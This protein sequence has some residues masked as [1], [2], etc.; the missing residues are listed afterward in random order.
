MF[1]FIIMAEHLSV[2]SPTR[3]FLDWNFANISVVL[4]LSL[5]FQ[6][7]SQQTMM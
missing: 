1:L 4:T 6:I 7:A 2:Q 3:L 5:V